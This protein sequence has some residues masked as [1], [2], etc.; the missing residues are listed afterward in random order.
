MRRITGFIFTFQD[1]AKYLYT[2]I[3]NFLY[4]VL[5]LFCCENMAAPKIT[6]YLDVVSPFAY[7]AFH[8]LRVRVSLIARILADNPS[9]PQHSPNAML[10]TCP[11][12]WEA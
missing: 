8:V 5:I 1:S 3:C 4:C 7:M 9:T 11:S 6:L 10:P 2:P 12:F